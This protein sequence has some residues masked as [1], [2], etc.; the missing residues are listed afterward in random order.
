[1]IVSVY[2]CVRAW[3]RACVFLRDSETERQSHTQKETDTVEERERE[4]QRC[5]FAQRYGPLTLDND[6]CLQCRVLGGLVLE[7]GDQR[8][9]SQVTN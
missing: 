4:R 3:V 8:P 7:G 1:M 9:T 5:G 2:A 6:R